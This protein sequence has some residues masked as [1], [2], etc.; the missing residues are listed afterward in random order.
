MGAFQTILDKDLLLGADMD[1]SPTHPVYSTCTLGYATMKALAHGDSVQISRMYKGDPTQ[2]VVPFTGIF[3]TN[4]ARGYL[5]VEYQPRTINDMSGLYRSLVHVSFPNIVPAEMRDNNLEAAMRGEMGAVIPFLVHRYLQTRLEYPHTLDTIPFI[6]EGIQD[7]IRH[8]HPIGKFL[9]YSESCSDPRADSHDHTVAY[10][11][12][13]PGAHVPKVSLEKAIKCYLDYDAGP[14]RKDKGPAVDV[15]AEAEVFPLFGC[16]L[17]QHEG[18]WS[19]CRGCLP[20]LADYD[21]CPHHDKV[22][23]NRGKTITGT[24]LLNYELVRVGP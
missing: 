9:T 14:G 12:A 13:K 17:L 5:G 7:R 24:V 11:R 15:C 1:P 21:T 16:E 20:V 2:L 3:A 10:V 6:K 18:N 8:L 19:A 4:A 23:G 22:G